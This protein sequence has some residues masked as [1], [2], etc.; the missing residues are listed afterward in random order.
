M[1]V[2]I[3]LLTPLL[4][5]GG[6]ASFN[7]PP[8]QGCTAPVISKDQGALAPSR[9]IG[10]GR[11]KHLWAYDSGR[12]TNPIVSTRQMD[13]FRASL[14]SESKKFSGAPIDLSQLAKSL[15]DSTGQSHTAAKQIVA[16]AAAAAALTPSAV[17]TTLMSIELMLDDLLNRVGSTIS[18]QLFSMRNHVAATISDIN[19]VFRDRMNDA[20]DKLNEQQRQALDRAMLLASD[21]QASLEKLASEGAYAASDLL[22][23]STVNFANYPNTL[24]GL[25]LPLERCFATDVACLSKIDVRDTGSPNIEQLLQFRGVNLLPGGE[26]P[27]AKLLINR[28]S[29]DVPTAG[30]KG[31][32]QVPLPGGINGAPGDLSLRGPLMGRIDFSWPK[33][34]IE[35]RWF[36]ELKPYQVRRVEVDF[37]FTIEGPVRSVRDQRC[38]VDAPGGSFGAREEFATCTIVPDA[39]DKSIERCEEFPPWSANGDAG[40][41]NR[42]FTLGACTWELRAKSKPL[43]GAGAW[44]RF[45]GRA[46]QV[47][48][49]R[50]PGPSFVA[51]KTLNQNESGWVIDYPV[52]EIPGEYSLIPGTHRYTVTITTNEGRQVILTEA[53]P[54]DPNV[55]SAIVVDKRLTITL[56]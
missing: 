9:D 28:S 5:L 31:V 1:R 24:V 16:N 33:N 3:G 47:R 54:A 44:Y 19:V 30:G 48:K 38:E 12:F 14:G 55:G 23:Q 27:N 40:I 56:K 26:Y 10:T 11:L 42:S 21:A 32:V 35:R 22:C 7:S 18:S 51:A 2:V 39:S 13:T 49:E 34:A 8:Q 17:T 37:S 6:C 45:I 52:G 46:H 25:G 29:I 53:K 15:D 41:R 50:I 43:W 20:Y 36:F 4:L